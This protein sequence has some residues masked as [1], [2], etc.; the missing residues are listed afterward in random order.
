V[1]FEKIRKKSKMSFLVGIIFFCFGFANCAITTDQSS[2]LATNTYHHRAHQPYHHPSY[3]HY[4][5]ITG[6]SSIPG[7][8]SLP[9]PGVR[10]FSLSESGIPIISSSSSSSQSSQSSSSDDDWSMLVPGASNSRPSQST[11]I[12]IPANLSLCQGVGYEHMWLPNL[13][14]HDSLSEAVHQAASW[15]PLLSE[16]PS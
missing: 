1:K 15:T 14:E 5:S 7:F 11:C 9:A 10:E 8:G 13:L 3:H 16:M 12:D 6:G 2:S 4:P